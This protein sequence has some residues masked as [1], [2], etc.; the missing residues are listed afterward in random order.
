MPEG[1]KNILLRMSEGLCKDIDGW[2]KKTSMSR[3]NAINYMCRYFL[4]NIE[5]ETL[6]RENAEFKNIL[7]YNESIV[8]TKEGNTHE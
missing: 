2:G 8:K 1:I 6:R 7:H 4:D 3:N 5:L